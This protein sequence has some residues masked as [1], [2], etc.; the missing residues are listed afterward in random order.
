M[1]GRVRGKV[2][3]VTGGG[4]GIGE[5]CALLLAREEAKVVVTDIQGSK[6]EAVAIQIRASGGHSIGI[7][8]DVTDELAWDLVIGRIKSEFGRL[9]ITIN[10]AGIGGAADV[11]TITLA[12]WR[13]V[14]AI[15]ME[16]VFLGTQRSIAIMKEGGGG[17]I[18]N[19][20]S[21]A[22]IVAQPMIPAYSASKGAV[23]LFSKSAALHCG[24][25]GLGIRVNS[26]HPGYILTPMLRNGLAHAPSPEAAKSALIA[27]TPIGWLG[28]ANDVAYGVLYLA[29]DE[30]RY[31]TGSELVI[32]GGYTAQ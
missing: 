23:K 21:I 9:D 3:V 1:T 17:S 18:V 11:E 15:N 6:A 14:M 2:A 26:V 32:D 16:G 20:S 8:H 31:V 27:E 24:R 25:S 28:E 30:S 22:G 13:H 7:S 4:S 5:A 29:S 12:Q 19:I 10:N